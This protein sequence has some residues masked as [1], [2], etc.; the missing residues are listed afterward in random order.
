M[1][2]RNSLAVFTERL[3]DGQQ[4]LNVVAVIL[5]WKMLLIEKPL[6]EIKMFEEN[7]LK[8]FETMTIYQ[9]MYGYSS[10]MLLI[11]LL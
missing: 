6:Q 8:A 5:F 7:K 2:L 3:E 1:E 4:H 10:R 11:F 9:Q